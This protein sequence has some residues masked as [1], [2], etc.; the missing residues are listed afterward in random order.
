MA[1]SDFVHE[2]VVIW[3]KCFQWQAVATFY[4][5]SK[6]MKTLFAVLTYGCLMTT[7]LSS[8]GDTEVND[9]VKVMK[10]PSFSLLKLD[11]SGVI[12][13]DSIPNGQPIILMYIDTEC[14]VCLDEINSILNNAPISKNWKIFLIGREP[15]ATLREY[16][17]KYNLN[18]LDQ[19]TVCKDPGLSLWDQ[20]KL[21]TVP[22]T[23]V[24]DNTGTLKKRIDGSVTVFD[25]QDY[26]NPKRS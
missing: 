7:I 3:V 21:K 2:W 18:M 5:K 24:Y 10:M 26:I 8:C 16:E 19:I 11:S 13:M 25:I 22:S 23:V 15:L 17:F 1:Q 4:P 6:Q 20:F 12:N 14:H 9:S